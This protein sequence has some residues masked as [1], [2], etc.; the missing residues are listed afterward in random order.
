[1]SLLQLGAVIRVDGSVVVNIM[2]SKNDR[3]VVLQA[4]RVDDD[5]TYVTD[6]DDDNEEFPS[7]VI[8]TEPFIKTQ[9]GTFDMNRARWAHRRDFAK[10]EAIDF[11]HES[12]RQEL[13]EAY[14][15][16]HPGGEDE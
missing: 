3:E 15:A 7:H 6:E 4:P 9:S 13:L 2:K 11:L 8:G 14:L 10:G 12:E 16:N 5:A 1:M